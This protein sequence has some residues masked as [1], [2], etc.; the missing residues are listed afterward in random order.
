MRQLLLLRHAETSP[1]PRGTSD[2]A[3]LLTEYGEQQALSMGK[4]L[5]SRKVRPDLILSSDAKRTQKTAE[6]IN[7][8]FQSKHIMSNTLYNCSAQQ[9]LNEIKQ[10][11]ESIKTLLVVNHNPGIH[12]L[13]FEL[14]KGNTEL[15]MNYPPCSLAHFVFKEES[16]DWYFLDASEVSL[17]DFHS[18]NMFPRSL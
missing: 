5:A 3:R 13:C 11:D 2:H 18:G 1:A 15:A 8:S 6:L 4:F 10:C 17:K 14:S 12:Q 16:N 9:L 7:L